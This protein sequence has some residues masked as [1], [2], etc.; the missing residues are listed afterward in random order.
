[1]NTQEDILE[2]EHVTLEYKEFAL[3]DVTFSLKRGYIT[4]LM[5]DNG[6]G[7]STLL[8]ML[9]GRNR[10]YKGAIRLNGMDIKEHREY[11]L[12]H[13]GIISEEP[14]FFMELDP[15]QNAELLGSFYSNWDQDC[16]KTMLRKLSVS[17][18]TPV[19]KLSRGNYIK[20]QF[21]WAMAHHPD[22]Y[23]MDEPTAGL[24]PVSRMDFFQM[25]QELV[26]ENTAVLMSTNIWSDVEQI[27]DY[28]LTIE[29]GR[30]RGM[31]EVQ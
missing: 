23:I 27:A 18:S 7:K 3:K 10:Q 28:R 17:G 11:Y 22:I 25:I 30:I 26:T 9:M 12:D 8:S 29:E 20:F 13:V 16:F 21:A 1:M 31:E 6:A 2:Y 5:G 4:V 19:G 15:W 24:D 14:F